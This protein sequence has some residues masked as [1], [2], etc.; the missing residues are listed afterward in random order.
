MYDGNYDMTATS[1][2][3]AEYLGVFGWLIV[4][5]IYFYFAF[6]QYKIAQK[7]GIGDSAWWAF[8]PILNTIL[9]I[10]M[11]HKPLWWFL[12]LLIP[13]VNLIAFFI[14]WIAAAKNCGQSPVW[15][16]LV[17]IPVLNVIAMS[18]LAF[19]GKPSRFPA[20]PSQPK[21]RKP[22]PVG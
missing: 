8:I 10:K 2:P 18:V 12:L 14:L 21:P 9:L 16:F 7:T 22:Q 6:T 15:G 1:S 4:L 13:G 20:K 11:A 3:A 5:A 17:M 19:T